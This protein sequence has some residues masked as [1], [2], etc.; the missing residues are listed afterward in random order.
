MS[1]VRLCPKSPSWNEDSIRLIPR[2]FGYQLHSWVVPTTRLP[3]PWR[4]PRINLCWKLHVL[5]TWLP[6][7]RSH[8][9]PSLHTTHVL[10]GFTEQYGGVSHNPHES[11]SKPEYDRWRQSRTG[12]DEARR[13]GSSNPWKLPEHLQSKGHQQKLEMSVSSPEHR[14][15]DVLLLD[16]KLMVTESQVDLR[17]VVGT[18]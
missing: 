2:N 15:R 11:W 6:I 12:Q 10:R 9:S 14:L 4:A 17:K 7:T 8:I 5:E 16:P 13:H 3:Q 18:Y 1:E